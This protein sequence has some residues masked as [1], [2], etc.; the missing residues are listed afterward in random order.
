MEDLVL[1]FEYNLSQKIIKR[2]IDENREIKKDDV[3]TIYHEILEKN[4]IECFDKLKEEWSSIS[5]NPDYMIL[6]QTYVKRQDEE[7]ARKLMEE[8]DTADLEE[9][10]E[11]DE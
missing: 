5:K 2:C 1:L 7:K 10:E 11:L 9:V 3:V 6:V 8:I 4:G